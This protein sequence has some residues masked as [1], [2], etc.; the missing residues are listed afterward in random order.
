MNKKAMKKIEEQ[1]RRLSRASGEPIR[2]GACSRM[3]SPEFEAGEHPSWKYACGCG[4]WASSIPA[5][6]MRA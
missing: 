4:A 2:C 5:V 3:V 6:V 1:Y